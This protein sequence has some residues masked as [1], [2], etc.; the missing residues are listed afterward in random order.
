MLSVNRFLFNRKARQKNLPAMIR[1]LHQ[2]KSWEIRRDAA[3]VLGQAKDPHMVDELLK[4]YASERIIGVNHEIIKA[5]GNIGDS[6]AARPLL[7]SLQGSKNYYLNHITKALIQINDQN[8]IPEVISRAWNNANQLATQILSGFIKQGWHPQEEKEK[9]VFAIITKN[10]DDLIGYGP[11]AMHLIVPVLKD[12]RSRDDCLALCQ[13]L[14]QLGDEGLEA[15]IGLLRKNITFEAQTSIMKVLGQ[16]KDKRCVR[17]L[18][19]AL[20]YDYSYADIICDLGKNATEALLQ[21]DL[22]AAKDL[23]QAIKNPEQYVNDK[24]IRLAAREK[25]EAL[26]KIK[27]AS[28]IKVKSIRLV[29]NITSL[30][31][32]DEILPKMKGRRN[33]GPKT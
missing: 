3:Q 21:M 10:W 13:V 1:Y 2:S 27:A 12:C 9:I 28:R 5:L 18:I 4:A 32:T 20:A 29:K 16:S 26:K 31:Y 11:Q 22:L 19:E 7:Q 33:P 23:L 8:I 25:I 17:P 30:D 15:L 14:V 6:R 24:A